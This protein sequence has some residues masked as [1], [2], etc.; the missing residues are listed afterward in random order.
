MKIKK[1]YIRKKTE[2]IKITRGT[3]PSIEVE[4][5]TLKGI[6]IIIAWELFRTFPLLLE[7]IIEILKQM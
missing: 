5:P 7:I 4:N 3:H 2:N 6:L 1:N